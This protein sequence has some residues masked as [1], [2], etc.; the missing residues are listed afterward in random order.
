VATTLALCFDAPLQS[1]GRESRFGI[2]ETAAEPTKSGVVGLLGAALGVERTDTTRIAE[3]ASL[4]LG[5]RADRP[6]TLERDYHTV[7]NVPTTKG[8]GHRTQ[9]SERYYLADA[10]FLVAL[11]G[12]EALLSRLADALQRPHWPLFF[13]RKAFPPA[14]PLLAPSAPGI[15]TGAGLVDQS[16][17][18][19]LERH[20]WLDGTQPARRTPSSND[21]WLTTVIDAPP[22]HPQ[23]EQRYDVPLTFARGEHRYAP[24]DVVVG[25][26]T[27]T[28]ELLPHSEQPC[29]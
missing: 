25:R 15:V 18:E 9:V 10:V 14:R 11:E 21:R 6:G 4:R 26:V 7:Q 29:T 13:G 19:A 23:A 17:D 28:P 2:R 5:V 22:D 20:I 12:P 24:R 16:L 27:L 8:T 3:L 1:W